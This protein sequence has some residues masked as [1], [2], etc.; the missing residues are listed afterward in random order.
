MRVTTIDWRWC[1]LTVVG[2]EHGAGALTATTSEAQAL[3]W[4]GPASDDGE[5]G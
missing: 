1:G 4:S 5:S 3:F 2:E